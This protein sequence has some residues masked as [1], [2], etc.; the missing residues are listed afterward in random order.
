MKKLFKKYKE[1]VLYLVFGVCTTLINL[2]VYYLL[3][4]FC[5]TDAPDSD[6]APANIIAWVISVTFAFITNKIWVFESRS[7]EGKT[8]LREGVSFYG[9]RLATL[10]M[11]MGILYVGIN[12]LQLGDFWVKIFANVLVIVANY[13]ASKFWIFRKKKKEEQS[14]ER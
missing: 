14:D 7:K 10:L 6:W 2:A 8:L 11:E 4:R 13:V 12:L 1:L 5:F 9:C 3:T